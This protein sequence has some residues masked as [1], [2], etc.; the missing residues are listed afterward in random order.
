MAVMFCPKLK[1]H[2]ATFRLVLVSIHCP[3]KSNVCSCLA[4]EIT[5]ISYVVQFENYFRCNKATHNQG[6]QSVESKLDI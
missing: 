4:L 5:E 6:V 1:V 2:K 3:L